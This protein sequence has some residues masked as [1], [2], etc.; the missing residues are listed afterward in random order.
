METLPNFAQP[1]ATTRSNKAATGY[2][3]QDMVQ[4]EVLT[5]RQESKMILVN[6]GTQ[7]WG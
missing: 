4:R 3:V 7:F 1:L 5:S 2:T 6:I